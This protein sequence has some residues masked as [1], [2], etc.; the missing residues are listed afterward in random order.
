MAGLSSLQTY[1]VNAK[2]K[3]K[4]KF[5]RKYLE[6]TSICYFRYR[7]KT[8]LMPHLFLKNLNCNNAAS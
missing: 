8:H 4:G 6:N 3:N 2:Q 7:C 1:P 5:E